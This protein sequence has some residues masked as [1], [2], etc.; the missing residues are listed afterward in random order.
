MVG[1]RAGIRISVGMEGLESEIR[2]SVDVGPQFGWIGLGVMSGELG[3][4]VDG[5]ANFRVDVLEP[6][7]LARFVAISR[8]RT[9]SIGSCS[10]ADLLHLLARPVFGGVRHGMAAVAIGEHFEDNRAVAVAAPVQGLFA[11]GLDGATSMPSTCSP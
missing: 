3:G 8:A 10:V 7:S 4:L 5:L 1:D 9:C 2:L 11:G 6:S